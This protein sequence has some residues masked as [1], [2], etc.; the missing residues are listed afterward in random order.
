MNPAITDT[1]PNRTAHAAGAV[2]AFASRGF[3]LLAGTMPALKPR[4]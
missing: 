4:H 1:N 2:G 3:V